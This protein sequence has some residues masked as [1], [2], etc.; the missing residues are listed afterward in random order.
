MVYLP[1][2]K[3]RSEAVLPD[4]DSGPGSWPPTS[5]DVAQN[6]VWAKLPVVPISLHVRISKATFGADRVVEH[7]FT[8]K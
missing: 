3:S 7:S 6:I 1:S 8:P 2:V 5:I 4:F